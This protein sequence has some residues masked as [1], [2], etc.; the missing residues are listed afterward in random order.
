MSSSIINATTAPINWEFEYST[1]KMPPG[2][3]G[4]FVNVYVKGTGKR[5]SLSIITPPMLCWGAQE[6]KTDADL[7]N[8]KY[9]FSH[10]FPMDN[11]KTPKSIQ[12][13]E[14]MKALEQQTMKDALAN[15]VEWFG[16]QINS[17]DVIVEKFNPMFKY[18]KLE[19]GG[20]QLN[21]DKPPTMTV[22]IPKWKTG[23]QSEI[24]DDN[25]EPLFL[26]KNTATSS[27]IPFIEKMAILQCIIQSAGIWFVNGK[28]SIT[29]NLKQA[30]V[31]KADTTQSIPDGV[32]TIPGLAVKTSS[33]SSASASE[34]TPPSGMSL[35][36]PKTNV[37]QSVVVDDTP[38]PSPSPPSPTI[39]RV[40]ASTPVEVVVASEK[41][42]VAVAVASD[43]V[44]PPQPPAT[45]VKK[46]MVAK[47]A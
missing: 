13:L 43:V 38:P 22:K 16:K 37:V 40:V 32:C 44:A 46:K 27:P 47:K 17:S 8:D 4:K 10:Q 18:P 7:P 25:G 35:L 39:E 30:V 6:G 19:T 23:W 12:Y 24:Y 34:Y 41:E 29:W 28:V 20:V 5:E 2:G 33:A 45:I 14:N 31:T 21:Y 42:E 36:N 11:F 15:S 3:K 1:P 9:T 26:K